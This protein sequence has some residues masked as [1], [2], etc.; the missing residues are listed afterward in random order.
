MT[1]SSVN[2]FKPNEEQDVNIK[3]PTVAKPQDINIYEN[4]TTQRTNTPATQDGNIGLVSQEALDNDADMGFSIQR[5]TTPKTYTVTSDP[6]T[7]TPQPSKPNAPA[8]STGDSEIV[9]ANNPKTFHSSNRS[10]K[11]G[12]PGQKLDVNFLMKNKYVKSEEEWNSMSQQ[13]QEAV[14]ARFIED[15]INSYN[16]AHPDKQISIEHQFRLYM[17][18]CSTPEEAEEL[19]RVCARL[20]KNNQLR[21]MIESCNFEDEEMRAAALRGVAS[22][23]NDF[24][25]DVK[26]DVY[27]FIKV[28]GNADAQSIAVLQAKNEELELQN[29]VVQNYQT[30]DNEKVQMT[31]ASHEGEFFRDE[32]GNIEPGSKAE[33]YQLELFRNGVQNASSQKAKECYAEHAYQ[34]TATNSEAAVDIVNGTQDEALINAMAKNA[35][36]FDDSVRDSI[37]NKL[38]NSGYDSVK[39]T[40]KEAKVQYEAEQKAKAEASREVEETESRQ[41]TTNSSDSVSAI[42]E[43]E[44]RISGIVNNNSINTTQKAKQIKGLTPKEQASAIGKMIS[45]ATLPEIKS[46]ALSGLKSEV[47]NYLFNNYSSENSSM[48][49]GLSDIM[50]ASEKHHFE[51]IKAQH[52]S[53]PLTNFFIHQFKK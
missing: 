35:Y 29:R 18:R 39:N 36:K 26:E 6:K 31:I 42:A 51:Q 25:Q 28:S 49:E 46:L 47:L 32:N 3:N 38:E 19:A 30:I 1:V 23:V 40:L 11:C 41:N 16:K 12:Q 24:D 5:T 10:I 20:D 44:K 22:R 13:E 14:K 2:P 45:S 50:T 53:R 48:L 7:A 9:R 34:L 15:A 43:S 27:G 17:R 8:S 4:A 33:Q 52:S 37:I 21:G